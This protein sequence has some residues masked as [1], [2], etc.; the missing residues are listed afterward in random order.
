MDW[1]LLNAR[2]Q[3]VL[4][5]QWAGAVNLIVTSPPYDN[6]RSYGGYVEAFDFGAIAP[7]LV[8][9]LAPGGALVWVT[10][11]AIVDG[12]ETGTSFRQALAFLDLGLRLHQTLIYERAL[13]RPLTTGRYLLSAQW[14]FVFSNGKPASVNLLRDRPNLEAGRMRSASYGAGRTKDGTPPPRSNAPPMIDAPQGKR[15]QVWRYVTGYN[16]IAPGFP[17]AHDHPAIFPYRLAADHIT[18]WSNPGDLVLD[19]MAGSGTTLRAA[20]NLGRRALGVEVNPEYCDLI[21]RRMAQQVLI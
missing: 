15:S 14:M 18:T 11:D 17:E 20:V 16:H 13:P 3:D 10:A 21:R 8:E 9:C 19:P 1:Q 5:G 6:L 4:P 12:S 2:A 7:A